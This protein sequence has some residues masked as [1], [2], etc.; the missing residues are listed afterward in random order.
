MKPI[1]TP[2]PS[3]DE[4]RADHDH[5]F[6]EARLSAIIVASE[7]YWEDFLKHGYLDVAEDPEDFTVDELDDES[8]DALVKLTTAYFESGA[9]FFVPVA[10]RRDDYVG[11]TRK[12]ANLSGSTE[13]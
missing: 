1:H 12:F 9:P 3:W 7:A 6:E 13:E 2:R 5:L 11:M 4:F 8:Y 10:L